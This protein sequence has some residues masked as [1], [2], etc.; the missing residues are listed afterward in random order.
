MERHQRQ[1]IV[2]DAFLMAVGRNPKRPEGA[3][4]HSDRGC[5]YTAKKTKDMVEK[6]GFHKSMSR[7][8]TPSDNQ[9]IESFWQTLEREMPDI[10]HLSFEQAKLVLLEYIELYYNASRLHSGIGYQIPNDFFTIF[11]VHHT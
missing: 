8:G 11:S 3:V 6:Y 5:Q 1:A 9:P 4:F 10:R 2:Q 7:P